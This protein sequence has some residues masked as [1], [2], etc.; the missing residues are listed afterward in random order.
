MK[1]ATG[2]IVILMMVMMAAAS[3]EIGAPGNTETAG[4][5]REVR[6]VQQQQRAERGQRRERRF[7][8]L[9]EEEREQF[10]QKRR[11]NGGRKRPNFEDMQ[12]PYIERMRLQN[13]D[14]NDEELKALL[15]ERF[16]ARKEA[17]KERGEGEGRHRER[18]EERPHGRRPK[19]ENWN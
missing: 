19:G 8:E 13:P 11:E 2:W 7:R 4:A 17:R 18:S 6:S 15:K 16:L 3:C 10:L 9:S 14:L 12:H 1:K 5:N